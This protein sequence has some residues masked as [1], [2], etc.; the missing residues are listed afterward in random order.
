MR[1]S[2]YA[3]ISSAK[4]CQPSSASQVLPFSTR[5]V[6]SSRSYPHI[7]VSRY[8]LEDKGDSSYLAK[9]YM[10]SRLYAIIP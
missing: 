10:L 6:I 4:F 2:S 8:R 1:S 7:I 9:G 5:A 3:T